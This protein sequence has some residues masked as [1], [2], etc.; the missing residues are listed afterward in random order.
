MKSRKIEVIDYDDFS[1]LVDRKALKEFKEKAM[2]P[3]N[4]IRKVRLRT[5]TSSSRQRKRPIK[6]YENVPDIVNDYMG[7]ISALT[8]REYKPFV[9]YGAKDAEN[10]VVAM[11]SCAKRSKKQS[12]IST[13]RARKTGL[14]KVHL[15]QTV[16]R[17]IFLRRAFR[18]PLRKSPYSTDTKEAG[19]LGE[20]LYIDIKSLFYDKKDQPVIVG[21][22]TA[23]IEG[24]DADPSESCF[25]TTSNL[26]PPKTIYHQHRGDDVTTNRSI[27]AKINTLPRGPSAAILGPR[28]RRYG[29]RKQKRHQDHRRQH[30]HVRA[31]LFCV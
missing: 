4:L 19:A 10:I 31:G 23:R 24:Y 25:T 12:I 16:Q 1:K 9:Y 8:G 13:H 7:K 17:E 18:N 26:L 20:P 11:G 14:I 28:L 3:M 2:S 29:R 6:F 21:A 22:F 27:P 5:P 30:R 15:L